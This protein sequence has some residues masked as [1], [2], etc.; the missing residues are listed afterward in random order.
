MQEDTHFK[1]SLKVNFKQIIVIILILSAFAFI[2]FV[3]N[4]INNPDKTSIKEIFTQTIESFK[5]KT[6]KT[7]E[8]FL[9]EIPIIEKN[10]DLTVLKQN[11]QLLT[12]SGLGFISI[13]IILG[14]ALIKH[15][16]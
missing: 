12:Y 1:P 7:D 16:I 5:I 13:S 2:P 10:I 3:V 9:V 11:P 6:T 4:Y 15:N 8:P 14:I